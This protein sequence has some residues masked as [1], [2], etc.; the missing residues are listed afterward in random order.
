MQ[1]G[2]ESPPG[3]TSVAPELGDRALRLA[4]YLVADLRAEPDALIH[5][6]RS[7]LLSALEKV[8]RELNVSLSALRAVETI[9]AHFAQKYSDQTPNT[10]W[11]S[12]MSVSAANRI[13]TLVRSAY[14]SLGVVLRSDQ[15]EAL[16]AREAA[17]DDSPVS[18]KRTVAPPKATTKKAPVLQRPKKK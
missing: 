4:W 2:V 7:V 8:A 3:N 15:V 5:L 18:P 10:L 9:E 11:L 12:W 1:S 16:A 13:T 6:E 17:G 14:T